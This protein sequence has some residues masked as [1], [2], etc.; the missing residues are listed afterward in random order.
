MNDDNIV[1][2]TY[3]YVLS[4]LLTGQKKKENEREFIRKTKIHKVMDL[5]YLQIILIG[6]NQKGISDISPT[7]QESQ[8]KY[9]TIV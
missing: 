5:N 3:C 2:H 9:S 6:E 8:N 4:V 1:T 7:L